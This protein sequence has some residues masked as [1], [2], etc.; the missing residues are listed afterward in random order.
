MEKLRL[1][2]AFMLIAVSS[3]ASRKTDTVIKRD[4]INLRGYIYDE[5]GNPI[6]FV[7]IQSTQMDVQYN[8]YKVNCWTDTSGYFELKGAKFNDTLTITEHAIY[9]TRPIYNRN[10]RYM[11]VYLSTKVADLNSSTPIAI[12]HKRLYPK[13]TSSFKIKA[14]DSGGDYFEVHAPA[15]FRTGIEKFEQFIKDNVEYPESAIKNNAEGT[16]QVEFTVER[17][18]RLTNFKILN[19]IGYG[20]DEAVIKVLK[21][22]AWWVPAVDNGLPYAMKQTVT[23]NFALTDK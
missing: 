23:V 3:F 5:Y 9:N 8:H 15:H 22:S 6:K 17:D 14:Y 19:G 2:I 4:T 18:G 11:V 12:T 1:F 21:K 20:C 7:H 13:I 10:S 16:V